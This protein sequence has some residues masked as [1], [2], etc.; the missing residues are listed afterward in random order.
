VIGI[1][2]FHDLSYP[3]HLTVSLEEVV[4]DGGY[5][6]VVIPGWNPKEKIRLS[7]KDLTEA[8]RRLLTPGRRFHA[9]VNLGAENYEELYFD[10]WESE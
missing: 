6:Y 5:F 10:S 4:A 8:M 1:R 3:Q 2:L 9:Q 7:V